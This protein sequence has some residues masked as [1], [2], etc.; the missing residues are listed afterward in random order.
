MKS[1]QIF[2]SHDSDAV[3]FFIHICEQVVMKLMYDQKM[4]QNTL[5]CAAAT[6]YSSPG[7]A[8]RRIRNSEYH[9]ESK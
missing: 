4:M 2:K 5:V 7:Q 8:G 6:V 3:F 1:Q 9:I